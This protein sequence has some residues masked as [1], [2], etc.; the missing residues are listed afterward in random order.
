MGGKHWLHK[1]NFEKSRN[2]NDPSNRNPTKGFSKS[3]QQAFDEI[4]R[5]MGPEKANKIRQYLG[6]GG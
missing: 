3:A 5:G 6:I 2:W 1:R 4:T